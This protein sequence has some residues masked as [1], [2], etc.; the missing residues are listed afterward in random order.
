MLLKSEL[1]G[2]NLFFFVPGHHEFSLT[3]TFGEKAH[4]SILDEEFPE[5]YLSE[6]GRKD[7]TLKFIL[8][9]D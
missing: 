1:S 3:F 4:Y 5:T 6:S 2:R 7:L 8:N 9:Q